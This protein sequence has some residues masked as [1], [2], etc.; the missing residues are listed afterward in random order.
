MN[1]LWSRKNYIVDQEFISDRY[2]YEYDIKAANVSVL[3]ACEKI[4]EEQ[5]LNYLMMP[6]QL[7]EYNIGMMIKMENNGSLL[8]SETYNTIQK[9]I[10]EAKYQLFTLNNLEDSQVIRVASDAVYVAK[11]VDGILPVTI[12]PVGK[13]TVQFKVNGP[14][15]VM[16]KMPTNVILFINF[17]SN[18]YDITVKGIKDE[19]LQ[20]H[21][22]M[23][24]F[25]CETISYVLAADKKSTLLKFKDFYQQY[26]N[27]ELPIEFYRE[28]NA[29]S[30]FRI[31]NSDIGSQFIDEKYKNYIDISFNNYILRYLYHIIMTYMR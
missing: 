25:I 9:G 5:Y 11:K 20:F 15:N 1:A 19:L 17:L 23:L 7:R 14:W 13:G 4:T 2:I 22:P 31:M 3:R 16:I 10:E 27:R 28:F 8:K 12:V 24:G 29:G 26:L 30:S 6:K 21:Q 18:G